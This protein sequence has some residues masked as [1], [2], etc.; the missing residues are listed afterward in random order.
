MLLC[1]A[2]AAVVSLRTVLVSPLLLQPLVE[3]AVVHGLEPTIAGGT[4]WIHATRHD[5][6]LVIEVRDD[7]QGLEAAA[8]RPRRQGTGLALKNLGERLAHRHADQAALQVDDAHPG[9][10][11]RIT[12]PFVPFLAPRS[13]PPSADSSSPAPT[14]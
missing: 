9:T 14:P 12:L 10:R 2:I 11:V 1:F 13:T 8:R 3:N 4:V 6:R 5:D 7:G